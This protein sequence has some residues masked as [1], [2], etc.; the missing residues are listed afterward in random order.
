MTDPRPQVWYTVAEAA[1]FC[2]RA[3]RTIRNL[4]SKHQLPRKLLWQVRQRRRIRVVMLSPAT[5]RALQQLTIER[6]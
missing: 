1:D 3:P 4:L 5:V 6:P 2:K